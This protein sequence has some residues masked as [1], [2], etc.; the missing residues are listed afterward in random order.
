MENIN[1]EGGLTSVLE[2]IRSEKSQREVAT[3]VR[4]FDEGIITLPVFQ[5]ESDAWSK[6]DQSTLFYSILVGHD[7]SNI[8]INEYSVNSNSD[9]VKYSLLN[10]QQRITLLHKFLTNDPDF[11]LDGITSFSIITVF[12]NVFKDSANEDEGISGIYNKYLNYCNK[13]GN[14]SGRGFRG[15]L[16]FKLLPKYLRRKI[17]EYNISVTRY[18][19]AS[20]A[21]CR[22]YFNFA[23][24]GKGLA[25]SDKIHCKENDL[26]RSVKVFSK[27]HIFIEVFGKTTIRETRLGVLEVISN[28]EYGRPLGQPK[29]IETWLD[30][31]ESEY[32]NNKYINFFK[33]LEMFFNTYMFDKSKVYGKTEIK[34]LLPLI[35]YG[36]NKLSNK[37]NFDINNFGN[38]AFAIIPNAAKIINYNVKLKSKNDIDTLF[39]DKLLTLLDKNYLTFHNYSKLNG[40]THSTIKVMGVCNDLIDLYEANYMN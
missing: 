3:L 38:F 22:E 12:Q 6:E 39:D 9:D 20:D 25:T 19:N 15:H 31:W 7:I 37:N 26:M 21:V 2:K 29:D 24:L 14:K 4:Q 36:F 13:K 16:T 1:L 40:S 27:N 10:G 32:K 35:I 33:T 5:R 8:T 17:N 28:I 30:R 11:E 18:I 23:Q 34:L